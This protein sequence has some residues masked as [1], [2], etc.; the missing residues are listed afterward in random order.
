MAFLLSFESFSV[1]C[2]KV[3]E[4]WMNLRK[5]KWTYY[6]IVGSYFPQSSTTSEREQ[7]RS[8]TWPT[9]TPAQYASSHFWA[10]AFLPGI[11]WLTVERHCTN[12]HNV[13]NHLI[14]PNIWKLISWHIPRW[15]RM[16]VHN[17]NYFVLIINWKDTCWPTV[18][19]SYTNVRNVINHSV[20]LDIWGLICSFTLERS[21]TSA[22]NATIQPPQPE[23]WDM[24][25]NL[26]K[27]KMRS[28]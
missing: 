17:A 8:S 23:H 6:I 5:G 12:V 15:G 2:G 24:G 18:E 11:C 16:N 21:L 28:N 14:M 20:K 25:K 1:F 7:F 27:L 10:L 9:N 3:K 22:N 19:W 4:P 13:T 26:K